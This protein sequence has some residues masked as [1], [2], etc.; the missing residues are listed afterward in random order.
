MRRQD[1][2]TKREQDTAAIDRAKRR[3]V[4]G[5]EHGGEAAAG[6]VTGGVQGSA[7][8]AAGCALEGDKVVVVCWWRWRARAL[9]AALRL[10]CERLICLVACC[11]AHPIG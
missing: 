5:G 10:L 11:P 6:Q 7:L 1:E 9:I 8:S 3:N 4:E 2:A